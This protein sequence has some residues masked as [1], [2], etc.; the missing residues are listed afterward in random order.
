MKSLV[1]QIQAR[2]DT[3]VRAVESEYRQVGR[4]A[5]PIDRTKQNLASIVQVSEQIDLLVQSIA[6][7]TVSHSQTA[8]NVKTLMRNISNQTTRAI[9]H[10]ILPN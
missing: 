7:A 4:I 1:E 5:A 3:A 6:T 8:K 10:K 9:D 2:T